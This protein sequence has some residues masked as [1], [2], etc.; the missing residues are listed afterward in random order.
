ME[1]TVE[2]SEGHVCQGVTSV[3]ALSDFDASDARL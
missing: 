1:E 3:P 2:E